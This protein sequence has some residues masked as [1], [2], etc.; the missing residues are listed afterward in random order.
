MAI[1]CADDANVRE[2]P[3]AHH[4]AVTTYGLG[5]DAQ[6]RAVDVRARRRADALHRA[7]ATEH[8]ARCEITLNLPG[9]HNVLNALAAIAVGDRARR[10]GRRRSCKALAEFQG[11]GRRFQRYG[12]VPLPAAAAS[13]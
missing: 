7:C 12:E 1:L 2:H 8:R 9:V 4:Q 3:A 11:V 5:A 13:R 6:V 10:A